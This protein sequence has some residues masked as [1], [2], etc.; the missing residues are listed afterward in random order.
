[1]KKGHWEIR[2]KGGLVQANYVAETLNEL[3]LQ[4]AKTYEIQHFELEEIVFV[5]D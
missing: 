3:V 4:L 2:Y 5:E 1:M